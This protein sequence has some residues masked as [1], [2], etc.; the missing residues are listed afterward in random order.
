VNRSISSQNRNSPR[1]VL[2]LLIKA[3][4]PACRPKSP[5]RLPKRPCEC[6]RTDF[7]SS[8]ILHIGVVPDSILRPD[9][10]TMLLLPQIR[11][12]DAPD[13]KTFGVC[14]FWRHQ[15]STVWNRVR[16]PPLSAERENVFPAKR[17]IQTNS[18]LRSLLTR[19]Q[20]SVSN[21]SE[22]IGKSETLM[23]FSTYPKQKI[24]TS[25][26]GPTKVEP[27]HYFPRRYADAFAR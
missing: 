7:F 23:W 18:Q 15:S 3:K 17:L 6:C 11:G 9:C 12:V 13:L 21:R 22:V 2:P 1:A 4:H 24:R 14:S 25:S 20:S 26:Y 16:T 10:L 19:E 5:P 27:W 8:G